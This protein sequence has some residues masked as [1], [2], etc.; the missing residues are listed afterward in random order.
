[1][2]EAQ[3]YWPDFTARREEYVLHNAGPDKIEGS[4]GGHSFTLPGCEDVHPHYPAHYEDGTPIP[5]TLVLKDGYTPDADGNFPK[6][7]DAYNWRA[8]VAIK[9][10]LG[11][12]PKTGR[13][14]GP[15]AMKGVSYVRMPATP[16]QIAEIMA[17]GKKR[18]YEF[19]VRWADTK[20][21]AYAESQERAKRA[22]VAAPPPD[23]D[24]A[25]A[26]TILNAHKEEMEKRYGAQQNA[27]EELEDQDELEF[28]AF[29]K[30]KLEALAEKAAAAHKVDKQKL[31]ESYLDDPDMLKSLRK[32]YRI[33][34]VGHAEGVAPQQVT[35]EPAPPKVTLPEKVE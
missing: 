14:T 18:Y 35:P 22:G 34:R 9:N 30:A 26:V 25:K 2:S 23:S 3:Q 31:V 20:V 29:A 6:E 17:E 10:V 1:M 7:G 21:R 32:K 24:Y 8:S 19:M 15:Y 33:R 13:A 28:M 16:E 4:W 11:I 5:G 12:D 27:I